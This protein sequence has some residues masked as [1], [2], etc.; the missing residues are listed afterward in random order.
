[1]SSQP[2]RPIAL[3]VAQAA[4]LIGRSPSLLY[5]EIRQ[6]RL[7]AYQPE[8]GY[9]PRQSME[10]PIRPPKYVML[11]DLEAWVRGEHD[12]AA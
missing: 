3:P 8:R 5:Q 1:M 2:L 10:R 9:R 4:K 11:A 7:K 6:G 12:D